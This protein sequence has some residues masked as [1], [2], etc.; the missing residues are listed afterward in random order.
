L[1]AF[2]SAVVWLIAFWR[3]EPPDTRKPRE[4]REYEEALRWLHEQID[5]VKK[6]TRRY[7]SDFKLLPTR[8]RSG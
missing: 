8:P 7:R 3:P 1:I 2:G 5:Y 6:T 4:V